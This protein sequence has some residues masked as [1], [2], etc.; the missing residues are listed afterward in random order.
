VSSS[1]A[2]A[3]DPIS[4]S[5]ANAIAAATA[6][7]IAA[8]TATTTAIPDPSPAPA[9]TGPSP[10]ADANA[11]LAGCLEGLRV[12]DLTRLL[13]GPFAAR[14]LADWG[15]EVV[16]IDEPGT[17]D[18][19]RHLLAAPGDRV[20][21]RDGAFYR[22]LNRGKREQR[23]D[24][25]SAAGREALL[26]LVD[27]ADA[28]VEGFR[29]GVMAR[30]GLGWDVLHARN[31]RLVMASIT[32]YGQRGPYARRAGH[33]IN[34]IALAGV[35][36]QVGTTAG[37]LA[38]PNFQIADLLG[39]TLAA[40][41]AL[42]AALLG[43]QRTGQ[44]RHVDISMTREVW[45]HAVVARAEASTLGAPSAPGGGLLSGGAACYGVY[46][47]ADGRHLA[48]GALEPLFWQAFCAAIGRP[49]WAGRHWSAGERPDSAAARETRAAVA[50][51]LATRPLAD[52]LAL[53]DPADCCVT[54]V[55]RPDEVEG[56]DWFREG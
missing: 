5:T 10:A 9:G 43:A 14:H 8:T 44:G 6:N 41:S 45:R 39:G 23:L 49:D 54:P 26:A 19:A 27:G 28:L 3:G 25:R 34:Y 53:T 56:H 7:T 46:R 48:V 18:A 35:L 11:G 29:P 24:L 2:S 21:G 33:D 13:P 36:G 50:A 52:W 30:L 47:T 4:T 15:A 42:L 20:A 40:T 22:E 31:P 38:L 51:L 16:K 37:E 55:L 32:G 1:E 12:L 17:G